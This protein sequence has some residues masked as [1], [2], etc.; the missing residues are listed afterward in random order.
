MHLWINPIFGKSNL[1]YSNNIGTAHASIDEF[2]N[3]FIEIL[4]V[5]FF[6][7]WIQ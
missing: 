5:I 4:L 3:N 1:F 7:S 2:V 6:D